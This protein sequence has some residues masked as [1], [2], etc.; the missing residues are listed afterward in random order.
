MKEVDGDI[1]VSRVLCGGAA[2]RS[3]MLRPGDVIHEINGNN[4]EGLSVDDVAD[5]MVTKATIIIIVLST[6]LCC[7]HYKSSSNF[8]EWS[9]WHHCVQDQAS[10]TRIEVKK[11]K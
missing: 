1:I 2:D 3:G 8:I 5:L 7:T 9:Y 10:C 11:K 4:L 6:L